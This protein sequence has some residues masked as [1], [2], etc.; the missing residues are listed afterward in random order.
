MERVLVRI[1]DWRDVEGDDGAN[2][3]EDAQLAD[4]T[5]DLALPATRDFTE[6]K[7]SVKKTRCGGS[8]D[9]SNRRQSEDAMATIQGGGFTD[10]AK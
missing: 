1:G 3:V 6:S 4:D 8:A 7:T 2:V 5:H 10:S 9:P